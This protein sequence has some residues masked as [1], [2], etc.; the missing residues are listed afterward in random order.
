MRSL[1][2]FLRLCLGLSACLF[3]SLNAIQLFVF[4]SIF[5][6][7]A[8]L[9]TRVAG[10]SVQDARDFLDV[11]GAEGRAAFFGYFRWVDTVFPPMLTLSLIALFR[12]FAGA[13]AARGTKFYA[14]LPFAYLAADLTEN[15]FLKQLQFNNDFEQAVGYAASATI[16]KYI[17]LALAVAVL[18]IFARRRRSKED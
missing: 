11:I 15:S 4:G 9:D 5:G 16:L 6:D 2:P 17:A 18:V 7:A 14:L 12:H 1:P 3:L 13:D 10:Y 8:S